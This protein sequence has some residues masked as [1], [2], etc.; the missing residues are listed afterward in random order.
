MSLPFRLRMYGWMS[1]LLGFAAPMILNARAAQGKEVTARLSERF[2]ETGLPRPEGRLVWLHGA[3]VGEARLAA[4]IADELRGS[5]PDLCF[6]FTT[7]TVTG[8]RALIPRLGER[9]LHQFLPLDTQAATAKF[10][11]HW[12]PDLGLFLESELWPNL[13]RAAGERGTRLALMNA[14]MNEGSRKHWRKN[15]A[16]LNWLIAR[17]SLIAPAD[18][19]TAKFLGEMG[20]K[21]VL[22]PGN[23]KQLQQAEAAPEGLLAPLQQVVGDRPVWLAASTHAE[24]EAIAL[25]AHQYVLQRHPDALLILVPRHPVRGSE[26]MQAVQASNLVVTRRHGGDMPSGQVYVADSIG[27]MALW[28]ALAGAVFM[29]GSFGVDAKGHNPLEAI[30]AGKPV[31]TGPGKSSFAP[32]YAQLLS[33]GAVS[34]VDNDHALAGAVLACLEGAPQARGVLKAQVRL[35]RTRLALSEAALTPLVQM[36]EADHAR[37]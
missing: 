15:K 32:V 7:Q 37:A 3:S 30:L 5:L 18:T 23:L 2:G 22:P 11:D 9:D 10:L 24:D 8:A 4:V 26:V 28:L 31:I 17:F 12:R 29:G 21:H 36:L 33:E 35:T 27:E 34:E 16:M 6:L 14:R 13:I 25:S 19:A 20:A 1:S